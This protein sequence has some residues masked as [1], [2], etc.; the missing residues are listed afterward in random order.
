MVRHL[1]PGLT[2]QE[3]LTT[4]SP[5][6]PHNFFYFSKADHGL[7]VYSFSRAYI[8]FLNLKDMES[9][10]DKFDGYVFVDSRGNEFP[11]LVEYAPFQKVPHMYLSPSSKKKRDKKCGTILEDADYQ[12]FLQSLEK[13]KGETLPSAETFLEQLEARHKEIKANRG[14]PKVITPLMEFVQAKYTGQRSKRDDR[15]PDEVRKRWTR[16]E[17]TKKQAE[18]AVKKNDKSEKKAGEKTGSSRKDRKNERRRREKSEKGSSAPTAESKATAD[19]PIKVLQKEKTKEPLR[20]KTNPSSVP[21]VQQ[22]SHPNK[23]NDQKKPD[24]R[25]PPPRKGETTVVQKKEGEAVNGKTRD[26]PA[27]FKKDQNRT[28]GRKERIPNKERP[29]IPIYRPGAKRDAKPNDGKNKETEQTTPANT[30]DRKPTSK[31]KYEPRNEKQSSSKQEN[32]VPF[33]TKVFKST[34]RPTG[35]ATT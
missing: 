14:C 9:F 23:Q 34:R 15:R 11:A 28:E 19:A 21:P 25:P 10:R 31:P 7:G 29:A 4:V 17:K 35:S 16:E 18:K 3:F 33:R 2:E 1:P 6:P 5:L 24:R 20:P 8:N 12:S 30:S 22:Q 26:P 27:S 13:E 32:G